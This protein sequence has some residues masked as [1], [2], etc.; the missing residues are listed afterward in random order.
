MRILITGASGQLAQALTREFQ[1]S[2]HE[3]CALS[4]R[5]LDIVSADDVEAAVRSVRP[6]VIL[7]CAAYNCV[8]AAESDEDLAFDV[9]ANGPTYLA[10]AANRYGASLVHYS[11]DFVFDGEAAA[12]YG[13]DDAAEPLSA[14]GRSKLAGER[15]A[16][17]ASVHY[18]LRLASVFGAP[19]ARVSTIDWLAGSMLRGREVSPFMDRTVSPSYT[20]DVA[21]ATRRLVEMA[22]PAGTYHCVSSGHC[23]WL[24]LA[25]ELARQLGVH[26][27]MRPVRAV[28]APGKARRPRF[29]A[30][31]NA[32]LASL[33]ISMPLWSEAI[34]R[35]LR[36]S[37]DSVVGS[38]I[39]SRA[40]FRPEDFLPSAAGAGL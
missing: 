2:G 35:H 8:D 4:H 16:A 11:T 32:R 17:R 21:M 36:R 27:R 40:G 5:L 29:S 20:F 14:Y 19:D 25:E 34:R 23:T 39:E 28:D 24:E 33:G 15:G 3:V 22:A 12:P 26:P 6:R 1:S 7:N 38:R 9:N 10:L 13:E 30:L 37:R 31:S 18:V